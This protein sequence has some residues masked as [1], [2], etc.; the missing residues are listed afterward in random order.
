MNPEAR[1]ELDKGEWR[2]DPPHISYAADRSGL[3]R[4]LSTELTAAPWTNGEGDT[5]PTIE[6]DGETL[7]PPA[8]AEEVD[9]LVKMATPAPYGRGEETVLDAQVRDARQIEAGRVR[10]SGSSWEEMRDVLLEAVAQQMGLA[11][12]KFEMEPLKLLIYEPGGHFDWHADTEKSSAMVASATLVLPGDYEGGALVVEHKGE[13]LEF[14]AGGTPQ[15]RWAAWYADCRHRL[16]PVTKGVR[17]AIT[18][19]IA[20]DPSTRLVRRESQARI[21]WTTYR[22]TFAENHTAWAARGGREKAGNTQYG[23]KVVWVLDHRYTEPGLRANLLKGRDRQLAALALDGT[24]TQAAFLAW[25]QIREVGGARDE[26]GR[27]FG[28]H[29]WR[30][31]KWFDEDE[32][33]PPPASLKCLMGYGRAEMDPAPMLD[34]H[35]ETPTLHLEDVTRQNIWVEGLRSLDGADLEYGPIE[36]EDGEIAPQ[37]TLDGVKPDGARVYEATGNEGASLELQYRHAVLVMWPRNEATFRMLARC[38]GRLAIAA[39]MARRDLVGR[40]SFKSFYGREEILKLW[41]EALETD[42]GGPCPRAHA[43]MI[44]AIEAEEHEEN[45]ERLQTAYLEHAGAIDLDPESG[46]IVAEWFERR[47]EKG[48]LVDDWIETLRPAMGN[49]WGWKAAPGTPGLLKAL[50]K[51]PKTQPLAIALLSHRDH[52]PG[53]I[54][55]VETIADE[56]QQ[57][58]EGDEWFGRR[59][60]KMT[61]DNSNDMAVAWTSE[62]DTGTQT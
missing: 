62:T 13:R 39:E 56:A 61:E 2:S 12:A 23:K 17:V 22:R 59:T 21:S 45:C 49:Q 18:F 3:V 37:G 47:L 52:A 19:G 36:I 24:S 28:D 54:E 38:G 29:E 44:K 58:L 6:V 1:Y 11:D 30:G 20:I 48:E 50:V 10:L 40:D 9:R 31:P 5:G 8:S 51:R 15:W 35:W 7:C 57:K 26:Q 14:A 53:S 27:S 41:A 60:S 46:K 16:E 25:L 4:L 33:D 42:G 32:Q 34:S 55:E 43:I